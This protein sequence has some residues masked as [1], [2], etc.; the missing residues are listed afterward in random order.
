MEEVANTHSLA[1]S[2]TDCHAWLTQDDDSEAA[3]TAGA[4]CWCDA[5]AFEGSVDESVVAD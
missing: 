5:L 3:C 2:P 4:C 1:E